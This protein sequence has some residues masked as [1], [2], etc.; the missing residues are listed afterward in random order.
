[1]AILA[2]AIGILIVLSVVIFYWGKKLNSREDF[3][4]FMG[5]KEE[6]EKR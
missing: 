4:A 1:M 3:K 6:K 2:P 5:V